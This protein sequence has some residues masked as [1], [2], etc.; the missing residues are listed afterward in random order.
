MISQ[1]QTLSHHRCRDKQTNYFRFK[2]DKAQ[3]CM[4]GLLS[5]PAGCRHGSSCIRDTVNLVIRHHL[6]KCGARG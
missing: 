5:A 6:E 4:G 3:H 2:Q 1:I